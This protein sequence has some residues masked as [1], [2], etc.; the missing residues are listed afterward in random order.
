[1]NVDVFR[2]NPAWWYYFVFSVPLIVLVVA[3]YLGFRSSSSV[4]AWFKRNPSQVADAGS[5]D[6]ESLVGVNTVLRWAAATGQIDTIAGLLGA[7]GYPTAS[8]QEIGLG[9]ASALISS[10]MTGNE[11]IMSLLVQ[12]NPQAVNE[13]DAQG[14]AA[15]HHA[16][17]E[18][19]QV[20]VAFLLNHGATIH[21]KDSRGLTALD[22]AIT[23]GD[24]GCT[25]EILQKMHG[26]NGH[27][28]SEALQGLT[29]IHITCVY[30]DIAMLKR[31]IAAGYNKMLK[32]AKGRIPP[33]SALEQGF[34]EFFIQVASLYGDNDL[35]DTD[36][37]GLGL[38]HAAVQQ[39]DL[40]T[41]KYLLG[42]GLDANLKAANSL[43]TPLH[44]I[45]RA[46]DGTDRLAIVEH[47]CANGASRSAQN[48][49]GSTIAHL[50]AHEGRPDSPGLLQHLIQ[51]ERWRLKV[52]DTAGRTPV[53]IAAMSGHLA[54]VKQLL[55]LANLATT[56]ILA[57]KD[58]DGLFPVDLAARAGHLDIF[59][60]LRPH[61]DSVGSVAGRQK[62]DTLVRE[63]VR[64]DDIAGLQKA[65]GFT[66]A[67][68][69]Q[70][71]HSSKVF[72]EA[73]AA[74]AT[75]TITF[76]LG[77]VP[78]W[79][80]SRYG[81]YNGTVLTNAIASGNQ[82]LVDFLLD[83][84]A[85]VEGQDDSGW[86]PLHVAAFWGLRPS[87]TTRIVS[88][89]GDK[90]EKD[91]CGWIPYDLAYFYYRT[92]LYD[93]LAPM[94]LSGHR[95]PWARKMES[96]PETAGGQ[97]LRGLSILPVRTDT[98]SVARQLNTSGDV[99]QLAELPC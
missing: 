25:A 97:R 95:L 75:Q 19:R 4:A 87:T 47:L 42:R 7:E 1:M 67:E 94:P 85:P 81:R 91:K 72:K 9:G 65:F 12:R 11:P 18:G 36:Y 96:Q 93:M 60:L 50:I 98:G 55:S 41:V 3:L 45:T 76:I 46:P 27:V 10:I 23:N 48:S 22:W 51:S 63:L 56:E 73:V 37:L 53:H 61:P 14:A 59:E 5:G 13:T 2:D 80:N 83:A 52:Q 24:D 89:M 32:D 44:V 17:G 79:M 88:K 78:G 39:G 15:L 74:G 43:K 49:A 30:H 31:L 99:T 57:I 62:F 8:S 64:K 29:S 86:N 77:K 68:N 33:F 84:D 38:L 28:N 82:D 54:T 20:M 66:E 26:K 69:Q 58:R 71:E 16:A 34:H 92:E 70:L 90:Y 6:F 40:D 35:R 21:Q